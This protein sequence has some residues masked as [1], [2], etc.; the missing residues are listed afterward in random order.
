[1]LLVILLALLQVVLTMLA[2]IAS[3]MA[4]NWAK[5]FS[6]DRAEV[7]GTVSF[8]LFVVLGVMFLCTVGADLRPISLILIGLWVALAYRDWRFVDRLPA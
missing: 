5:D 7:A 6:F 3:G 1:M 8:C 4:R 2:L